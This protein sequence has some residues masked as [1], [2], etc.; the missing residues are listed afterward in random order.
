[1]QVR[2]E[3]RCPHRRSF[4]GWPLADYGAQ[5]ITKISLSLNDGWI[6][7][8]SIEYGQRSSPGPSR[9]GSG[10]I[11]SDITLL[12][13]EWIMSA[14]VALSAVVGNTSL[15][16]GTAMNSSSNS[17]T[18]GQRVS[19][20]AFTTSVDRSWQAGGGDWQPATPCLDGSSVGP[21]RLVAVSGACGAPLAFP[22]NKALLELSLQWATQLGEAMRF[23]YGQSL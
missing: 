11:P 6:Q 7:Q 13:G 10:G 9:C 2:N 3:I 15:G 8:F 19:G 1:M 5:P 4:D 21:L 22:G 12:P 23:V 14:R 18:D 17:S 16:N 20:F